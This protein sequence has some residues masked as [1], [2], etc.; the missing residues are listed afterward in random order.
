MQYLICFYFNKKIKKV[1]FIL[2]SFCALLALLLLAN[3][4]AYGQYKPVKFSS[5]GISNGLSQSD[6]KFIIK[7][8]EGFLWFSTDDGLNRYDGY[9][10]VVYRH[11]YK[12]RH[13]LP[14]N[15]ITAIYED[16]SGTLW[17]GST[18][19]LS[20]YN[21]DSDSFTTLSSN[22]TNPN[23]LT[24]NEVD[25]IFSDSKDH[26]WVATFSG[27]NL[28]DP[29]SLTFK[30]YFDTRTSQDLAANHIYSA[31]E[32]DNG[33]IWLATGAGISKLDINSGYSNSLLPALKDFKFNSCFKSPSGHLYAGSAEKGM[34]DIDLKNLTFVNYLHQPGNAASIANNTVFTFASSGKTVWVG[35]EDGLDIFD[36]DKGT[37]TH[38]IDENQLDDNENSSINSIFYNNGILWVGTY[39]SGIKYYDSNLSSFQYYYKDATKTGGISNNIVTSFAETPSGFWIGTD[40]GGLNFF[41]TKTQNFNHYSPVKNGVSGNHILRLLKDGPNKLWIGYYD[42]GLDLV[43]LQTKKFTHY[44]TGSN[45]NQITNGS[46]FAL[47][48]GKNNDL[49]VGMDDGGVNILHDD[50]VVKRFKYNPADT[51]HSLSNNDV[52]SIYKDRSGN[53][54]VGTY[55]GLNIYN[56][57]NGTFKH[58]TQYTS[59]LSNNTIVSMLD[60]SHG[61]FWVGT[62]GGGLNIFNKKTQT[63]TAYTFPGNFNFSIINSISEDNNGFIWL[64]TNK[65]LVRFKPLTTQFK[66]YTLANNMQGYEFFLG[67]A[68]KASNGD[69][70][71]GGHNGFNI[72][73]PDKISTN[74]YNHPVVFTD[75]Q[76]F[77]KKIAIGENA[78][79]KQS[80]TQTKVIKLSYEQS[81]FTIEYSSLNYTLPE[82][83]SYAYMLEGF[84]HE[85]N[86]VG[87]QRKATYTNLNPGEYTFKVKVA[88]SDGIW[89]AAP[90][91]LEIIIVPPL[92]MTLWFR[93]TVVLGVLLLIYGLY[94]YRIYS[95]RQ[96]QKVLQ[97]MVDEKTVAVVKQSDELHALNMELQAQSEELQSQSDHLMELNDEL[98]LQKEQELKARHEAEKA[99]L[100]KGEFLAT[101]S[102]EIRTPMN[103]VLGMTSL[104]SETALTPEQ[105][106][107]ADIIRVS[108]ESLLNVINDILDFSKIESGQMELD[109]HA[110]DLR[111]CVEEVLDIFSEITSKKQLDLLY[112]VENDV[113]AILIGDK[114]R[115]RQI[116]IN[117][118]NN[119]IKFTEKGH[120]LVDIDVLSEDNGSVNLRFVIKDT[121]IGIS[122]DK[123]QRLFKAFSQGDASTT[124]KYGGTGLG[125][126]ICERLVELMGGSIN[127]E[128]EFEKGT[129]V[130]FDIK[131]D[132]SPSANRITYQP[133]SIL[134]D[135]QVLLVDTNSTALEI[136]ANEL[137]L[138]G[139][140]TTAVQSA[141]QALNLLSTTRNYALVIAGCDTGME[142]TLFVQA[143]KNVNLELILSCSV[144][145]KN[146]YKDAGVSILLKPVKTQQLY[147]LVK[148]KLTHTDASGGELTKTPLLSDDFAR[149][150]PMR[151]LIAEDNPINQKLISRVIN[152]L[153]F[154][155]KVVNNGAEALDIIK[156]EE[157]DIILMDVQMPELD[158][159]EATRLIR[160]LDITQP[161]ILAMTASAMTEDKMSTAEA[162]MNGFVSK[163]INM[164]ELV[165]ELERSFNVR[166]KVQS[167]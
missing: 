157:F 1:K 44:S 70:L 159:L 165:I 24:N 16:K 149:N 75:F 92:W 140:T 91:T 123:L 68:L 167:H 146:K 90:S 142:T 54:W 15:A 55:R 161:Y 105:R 10:F 156:K 116:L 137:N 141:Q 51:L 162:G 98:L 47:A 101:M 145:D 53:I 135:K 67:S 104:L 4:I 134:K 11:Q 73:N 78:V 42:N 86:Y 93:V 56:E 107:Y 48:M 2:S 36:G 46:I 41:N 52:R 18:N 127:I 99:N 71:F 40:G 59:G 117:L 150:F 114:L 34:F 113:P 82:T 37:F 9:N 132:F 3:G 138:W 33:N 143:V 120:I 76:L 19:G 13:S 136:M 72:V 69:L 160:K 14:T 115:V 50:K 25:Y 28:L 109:H 39:E 164:Q 20:R 88:N 84:E 58:F 155:P 61:N 49:W 154:N 17:V 87:T 85:W 106:E 139:I 43:N 62:L 148:N 108:G 125:L 8:H 32:D 66:T 38:Y 163:P 166:Q 5:L 152:R 131:S 122:K 119:A 89:S 83:N 100:A 23:T 126:V 57:A 35:T 158:G 81:V 63:F 29:K 26:L 6:V 118:I 124:R 64:G 112:K 65:G 147:D 95:Y 128:S 103:G 129:S 121:G 133:I 102:H 97:K 79:L 60:D 21:R 94:R 27:L 22:K 151:I 130:I 96:N 12:N 45:P 77:N 7:D 110:Y 153:G 30:R 80:I 74:K 31:A 144:L 111:H